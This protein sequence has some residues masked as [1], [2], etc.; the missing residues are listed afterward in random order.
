MND[1]RPT[2]RPVDTLD[3]RVTAELRERG[4]SVVGRLLDGP[5]CAELAARFETM[6][7]V[8]TLG[9]HWF[10]SGMLPE[11]HQR[12]AVFDSVGSML[13]PLLPQ[14]VD[15]LTTEVLAGH[16]HV[17][18]SSG[19]GGLGPHQ[20][21]AIVDERVARSVN[22]WIPLVDSDLD[23]GTLQVVEGSHRLG[24]HDRSLAMPWAFEGLHDLFWELATPLVVPAGTLVLFDTA[25]VHC[26]AGNTSGRPRLAVNCLMKPSTVPLLHLV[27]DERTAPGHVDA[28]DVPLEHYVTGDLTRRPERALPM[29]SRPIALPDTDPDSIR[30]ICA[31]AG[32][33]H[34]A[35]GSPIR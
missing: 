11:A 19:V 5:S 12:A 24:N 31:S 29:T 1:D 20:D 32:E 17:N 9:A 33:P 13:H 35:A 2:P 26:S 23:N 25:V 15:T 22:G 7:G 21:V 10:T 34:G 3:P 4:V 18:P 30:R 16:Y 8:A 27:V 28:Y 6:V 14:V